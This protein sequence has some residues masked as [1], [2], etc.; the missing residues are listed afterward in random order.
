MLQMLNAFLTVQALHVTAALGIADQLTAGPRNIDDLASTTI[1]AHS[2]GRHAE[3]RR[4]RLRPRLG[5]L[6]RGA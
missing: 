6:R 5:A 2:P 3:D 1:R 4:T